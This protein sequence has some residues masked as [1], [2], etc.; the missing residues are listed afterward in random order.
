[1]A[2]IISLKNIQQVV[3]NLPYTSTKSLKSRLVQAIIGI[4]KIV[5]RSR[6]KEYPLFFGMDR[7]IQARICAPG[8]VMKSDRLV[9]K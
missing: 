2:V 6:K 1:M 3:S 8:L 5:F 7:S 9:A 4:V